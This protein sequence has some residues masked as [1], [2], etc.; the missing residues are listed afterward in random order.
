VTKGLK[1]NLA[2]MPRI[3]SIDP[4]QMTAVLGTAHIIREVLQSETG[5]LSGGDHS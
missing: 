3:H 2:A 4:L 5:N 1:K